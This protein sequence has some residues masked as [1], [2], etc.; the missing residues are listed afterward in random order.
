MQPALGGDR[1]YNI[2]LDPVQI[3]Y[4]MY[5]LAN[6]DIAATQGVDI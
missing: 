4:D 3:D 6:E 1:D 2:W 5:T